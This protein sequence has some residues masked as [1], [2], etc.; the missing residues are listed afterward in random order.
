MQVWDGAFTRSGTQLERH[1][2]GCTRAGMFKPGLFPPRL[3]RRAAA[4]DTAD[5]DNTVIM[6]LADRG[7]GQFSLHGLSTV[8]RW[9]AAMITACTYFG[10]Q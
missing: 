1:L 10:I 5:N 8:D 4:N 3:E 9:E 2:Q 6:T 7:A